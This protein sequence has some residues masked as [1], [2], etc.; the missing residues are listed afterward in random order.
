MEG[1][2]EKLVYGSIGGV[3]ALL[4]AIVA[5]TMFADPI[6]YTPK[7]IFSAKALNI[8]ECLPSDSLAS[9]KIGFLK[10]MEARG[11]LLTPEEYTGHV[12]QFYSTLVAVLVGL[13]VA[14]SFLSFFIINDN[15]NKRIERRANELD[16]SVK[17]HAFESL[18]ELLNDSR[19]FD[20]RLSLLVKNGIS[21]D[22]V[23]KEDLNLVKKDI[24]K[25]ADHLDALFILYEELDE[26]ISE[27]DDIV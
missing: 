13:F 21:K 7:R 23:A 6:D 9:V 2:K 14:F 4:L 18:K 1:F 8:N 17:R 3:V 10:D 15:A 25:Y 19:E 26:R 20:D 24:L 22:H 11:V 27:L 16:K 12:L 5:M